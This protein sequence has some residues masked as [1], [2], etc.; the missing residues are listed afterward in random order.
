MTTLAGLSAGRTSLVLYMCSDGSQEREGGWP[1]ACEHPASPPFSVLCCA[2]VRHE[3]ADLFWTFLRAEAA[4]PTL[5]A[6]GYR[7]ASVVDHRTA[8]AHGPA[9]VQA[10]IHEP[11]KI[12]MPQLVREVCASRAV[13]VHSRQRPPGACLGPLPPGIRSAARTI[14]LATYGQPQTGDS[15]SRQG[16]D[17]LAAWTLAHA[18]AI[19]VAAGFAP[20]RSKK[21]AEAL[22]THTGMSNIPCLPHVNAFHRRSPSCARS[23]SSCNRSDDRHA[24]KSA[25]AR[26]R[27]VCGRD[28]CV[29]HQFAHATSRVTASQSTCELREAWVLQRAL[30]DAPYRCIRSCQ[31]RLGVVHALL[32]LPTILGSSKLA[33]KLRGTG[34]CRLTPYATG[35]AKLQATNVGTAKLQATSVGTA[36]LQATSVGTAKLQATNVGTTK[37]QATNVGT[38]KL[39]ATSVG[40]AKLQAT[41]VGTAKLQATN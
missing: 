30:L 16:L 32:L 15:R 36:K 34:C 22:D 31:G 29:R 24:T 27:S 3:W 28:L 19:V 20:L 33:A 37:L 41:S 40:T 13:P 2:W 6:S 39:Q 23:S 10:S 4:T 35:A 11:C 9:L 38:A 7:A 14:V 18:L 17:P 5:R 12:H 21:G 8:V 1:D 26:R 25:H